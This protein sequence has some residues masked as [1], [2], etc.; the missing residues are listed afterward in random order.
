M[1]KVTIKELVKAGVHFGHPTKRWNPKM[2]P[3]VFGVRN[4]I[5]IIDLTVTMQKLLEACQFLH[6]VVVEGKQILFVGTKRQ[7]QKITETVAKNT[8]MHYVSNRWLGGTLT[9]YKTIRKSIKKM[10]DIRKKMETEEFQGLVKKEQSMFRRDKER[11]EKNLGGIEQMTRM[12]GVM[13][14][15][16]VRKEH[17]AVKE[18]KRL[19]IPIVALVDTDS[20]PSD[21]DHVIPVND[22]AVRS[23]KIIL[24]TLEKAISSSKIEADKVAKEKAEQKAQKIEEKK[25]AREEKKKAREE[26]AKKKK[27][28]KKNTK[29]FSDKK[30]KT[31]VKKTVDKK[32]KTVVKKTADKK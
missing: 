10:Q 20:D 9:N 15:V 19:N 4:N 14:I 13:I 26:E 32:E 30:E 21:I 12:P 1:A 17:N 29:K 8:E 27:A 3:Y 23:I 18:A 7:A 24:E 31:V 16:D 6:D 5:N 28:A 11:I 25:K 2:L 22:D